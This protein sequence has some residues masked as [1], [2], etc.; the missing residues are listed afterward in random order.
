M[1]QR[2]RT[3]L[4]QITHD[5]FLPHKR[6]ERVLREARRR[7]FEVFVAV[8]DRTSP[9]DITR[10]H[11][12]ADTVVPFTSPGHCEVAY[13]YVSQVK[14]EFVLLISDDEAPSENLW[15]F[16]ADPP[17]VARY[18]IPVLPVL[19]G[20]VYSLDLGIQERLFATAGWRWV[21]GFEGTSEGARQV[22]MDK[23]PG[24]V[25][26]HYDL[27][28]PRAEREAKAARYAALDPASDHRKRLIWEEHPEAFKDLPPGLEP[29]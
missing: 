21:G 20:R 25:V 28:A 11:G 9:A 19:G 15:R 12:L 7:G 1:T 26:W 8:D 13:E 22:Y 23:N 24:I 6:S 4:Y 5:P 27:E 14:S 16:A 18:G 17:L 29:C 10:L 2:P 3:A